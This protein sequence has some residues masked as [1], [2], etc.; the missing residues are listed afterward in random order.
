MSTTITIGRNVDGV[1][2]SD[3]DWAQFKLDVGVLLARHCGALVTSA[4]GHGVW[5]GETEQ[6]YVAA[7]AE[8]PADSGLDAYLDRAHGAFREDVREL[9]GMWLQE[10][11]AVVIADTD[12]VGPA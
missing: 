3:V 4:E 7:T 8:S 5:E 10:A 12:L 9:S 6:C 1:P 11:I 2:M